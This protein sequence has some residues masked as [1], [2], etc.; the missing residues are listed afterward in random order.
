MNRFQRYLKKRK[1]KRNLRILLPLLKKRYGRR[2]QYTRQQVEKTIRAE[3]FDKQ[4]LYCGY[5]FFTD[6]SDLNST[7]VKDKSIYEDVQVLIN[8]L[9]LIYQNLD[10]PDIAHVVRTEI[11]EIHSTSGGGFSGD[12]TADFADSSD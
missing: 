5:V 7:V 3:K 1:I 6:L 4:Y 9:G 11:D 10:I 2:K 8:E 12:G